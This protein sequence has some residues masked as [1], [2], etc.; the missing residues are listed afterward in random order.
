M[1]TIG[2]SGVV[3]A[4][5]VSQLATAGFVLLSV[6]LMADALSEALRLSLREELCRTSCH[7]LGESVLLA[8]A[9]LHDE[10]QIG[11]STADFIVGM[12]RRH[13]LVE[14]RLLSS[15]RSQLRS[16]ASSKPDSPLLLTPEMVRQA[17]RP[18]PAGSLSQPR[19]PECVCRLRIT[20]LTP[21]L[22]SP[23]WPAG[24][25]TD[26]TRGT[27]S[28]L[29]RR[30]HAYVDGPGHARNTARSELLHR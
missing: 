12:L 28:P 23:P 27:G 25:S 4:T 6:V 15:L 30:K 17:S 16:L 13:R 21:P 19:C 9:T 10:P 26:G 3:P 8:E 14:P 22:L 24:L 5:A 1:T 20:L 29:K 7:Q 11:L 2:Y 18:Q